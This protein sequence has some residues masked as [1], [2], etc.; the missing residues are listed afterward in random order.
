[1][2][3]KRFPHTYSSVLDELGRR[4]AG[5][6][7][8]RVQLLTGPRQVGKTHL[9]RELERRFAGRVVYAAADSP[10]ASLPGWWEAQ[11][12]AAEA[13]ARRG[14]A[15]IL[16]LDEIQYVP[17]WGRRL[18]AE[19]DRVAH[20]KIPL[21]VAVSGSSSLRVGHGA[22]ETMAGRFGVLRLLHWPAREL[23][24]HFGLSRRRAVEIAVEFGTYPGAVALLEQPDRVRSYIADAIVEPAIGRDLVALETVRRPALLRQVFAV[25]A[26]H[27]A[28]ILSLQK[29]RGQLTDAGALETLAHYRFLLEQ[30]YLVAGLG[31]YSTREVR[32]RAAPPKLVVLNQGILAA[33]AM[34]ASGDG[35]AD[36][37]LRGRWLENACIALAWNAGQAVSYWREEP[38]EVDLV[39]VG[40]WGRWAVEVKSGAV[41]A[42]DLGGLLAFCARHRSVRPLLVC[43]PGE[44]R[45]GR[46]AGVPTC[47]WK[48]FLL[49]GP[50]E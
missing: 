15:G 12:S 7:P 17:A 40:S 19:A 33:T 2:S 11:W 31:K 10:A 47:S 35:L 41:T 37:R 48:Q 44:E 18:K 4:L 6:R 38:R 26:G 46:A 14:G 39:S 1:M 45:A 8:G 36:P 32:R 5:A 28:E 22:R 49:D 25:A 50:P 30:A 21:H 9:L 24:E 27:P 20:A 13:V 34:G 43:E 29:M 42:G 3:D 23:A 16:M